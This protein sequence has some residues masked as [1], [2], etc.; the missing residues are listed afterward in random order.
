M[1]RNLSGHLVAWAVCAVLLLLCAEVYGAVLF[2]RQHGE[3]VYRNRPEAAK[4]IEAKG[5]LVRKERLHPYLGW[6]GQ[7][8][9]DTPT[10]TNNLGFAQRQP[11]QVP[12]QPKPNDIIVAVF[13]GSVASRSVMAPEGGLPL[14]AALREQ[15]PG[16]NVIVYN[17]AQGAAKQ[18]QQ[19]MALAMLRALGQHIDVVLNIDGFNEF[20][21]GYENIVQRVHPIFPSM[22][23]LWQI[24][25]QLTP[26]TEITAE[27]FRIVY[28]LMHSKAG[29][30][31]RTEGAARSRSGISFLYNTLLVSY[32]SHRRAAALAEQG[33]VIA[34]SEKTIAIRQLL[35]LDMPYDAMEDQWEELLQIWLSSSEAMKDL[36]RGIGA[37]YLHIIQPNQ[38][39]SGRQF[40][41][42]EA[43]IALSMPAEA[44]FRVGAEHGY[45]ML[46]Q[47]A[48]PIAAR[49]IVSAIHLFDREAG[50][51]Y[52][53]NCCHYTQEGETIFARYVAS[54]IAALPAVGKEF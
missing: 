41:P 39:V 22:S 25:S 43:K 15:Y 7:Y 27:H 54:Q 51:V 12:F 50:Q 21:I 46:E 1:G 38:Y 32:H 17:M 31:Q 18:P 35:G 52:V 29:V 24:S 9:L 14:E 36:S 34:D 45:S 49:G 37:R 5:D 4:P 13:G 23:I 44:A 28:E 48:A 6:S 30:E 8:S 40:S 19:V 42:D 3:I 47:R 20:A 16:K 10:G 53:D 26:A 33:S 11:H 2:Y